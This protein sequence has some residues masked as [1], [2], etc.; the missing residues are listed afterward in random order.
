M[1]PGLGLELVD[2]EVGDDNAVLLEGRRF[3]LSADFPQATEI[4]RATENVT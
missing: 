3:I 1:F 4:F 2:V